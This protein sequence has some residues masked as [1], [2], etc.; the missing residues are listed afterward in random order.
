[1][2]ELGFWCLLSSRARLCVGTFGPGVMIGLLPPAVR[3]IVVRLNHM[4]SASLTTS[5][6]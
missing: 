2:L 3:A 6:F 5:C 4:C 1:M